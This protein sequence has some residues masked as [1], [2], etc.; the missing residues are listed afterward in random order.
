M[1][2]ACLRSSGTAAKVIVSGHCVPFSIWACI[3]YAAARATCAPARASVHGEECSPSIMASIRISCQAGSNPTSSMRLPKRSCV[4]SSGPKRLARAAS[5]DSSALPSAAPHSRVGCATT[6]RR[7]ARPRRAARDRLDR[8]CVPRT[9]AAGWCRRRPSRAGSPR[10]RAQCALR[11]EDL[12][13]LVL[14]LDVGPPIRSMQY[15]TAERRRRAFPLIAFG[16]GKIEDQR[17]AADDADR[18]T[19]SPSAHT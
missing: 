16:C 15:G 8:G 14:R 11:T 12:A 19:V 1:A 6:P 10:R 13:D 18:A 2:P 9:A 4:R 17:A 7:L 3:R 5:A